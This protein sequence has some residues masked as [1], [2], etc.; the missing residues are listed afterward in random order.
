MKLVYSIIPVANILGNITVINDYS[1][2][3]DHADIIYL[4]FSKVLDT[5]FHYCLLVIMKN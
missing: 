4:N 5:V 2:K 3:D 1:L